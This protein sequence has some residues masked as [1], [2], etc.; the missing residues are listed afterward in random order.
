MKGQYLFRGK[1]R[2]NT[3]EFMQ[4]VLSSHS[5][6]IFHS[7]LIPFKS[8]KSSHCIRSLNMPLFTL[9][10]PIIP[11]HCIR[12]KTALVTGNVSRLSRA[13]I[14]NKSR[15]LTFSY[16]VAF[17]GFF[18]KIYGFPLIKFISWG[19]VVNTVVFIHCL[20]SG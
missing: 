18:L 11:A 8:A 3:R 1:K 9:P 15:S 14:T 2:R 6:F 5:H 13:C 10:S 12:I 16:S 19:K 17:V 20:F 7:R 4:G